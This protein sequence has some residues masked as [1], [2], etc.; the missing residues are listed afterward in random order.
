[1][2]TPISSGVPRFRTTVRLMQWVRRNKPYRRLPASS[3]QCF[4]KSKESPERISNNILLYCDNAGELGDELES[5]LL[6]KDVPTYLTRMKRKGVAVKESLLDRVTDQDKLAKLPYSI[7]RLPE[8]A[9]ARI[10][11]ASAVAVYAEHVLEKL[12]AGMESRLVGC[13]DSIIK[14]FKVLGRNMIDPPEYLLKALAGHDTTYMEV[15]RMLGGLL[16]KYLEDTITTPRV[17]LWYASKI[18]KG[19]LPSHLEEVLLGDA[20]CAA[21]YAFDVVRAYSSPRLPDVLHNSI[22]MRSY[23]DPNNQLIR[24]Y[25]AEVERTSKEPG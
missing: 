12:P 9:E 18:L 16:P 1:M 23:S 24:Q 10:T 13:P 2:N 17:A 15:S 22:L 25:V 21:G 6:E 4:F 19:R 14:Y 8:S 7:G 5:C 20:D 11:Q 3:E